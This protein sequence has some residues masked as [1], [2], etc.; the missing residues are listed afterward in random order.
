MKSKVVVKIRL[1]PF[2]YQCL[3]VSQVFGAS[4]AS[5]WFPVAIVSNIHFWGSPFKNP[6][7][8]TCV[9]HGYHAGKKSEPTTA[10]STIE[11]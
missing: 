6:P 3:S 5:P 8:M 2:D 1:P 10:Q 7:L 4:N 9:T 11:G